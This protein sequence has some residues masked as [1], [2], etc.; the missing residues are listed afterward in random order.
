MVRKTD[1]LIL[2]VPIV[3]KSG[4]LNLLEPLGLSRPVVGLLYRLTCNIIPRLTCNIIKITKKKNRAHAHTHTHTHN[5]MNKGMCWR[6]KH[7]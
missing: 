6:I 2:R 5:V 4:S 7:D 3:L 1:N